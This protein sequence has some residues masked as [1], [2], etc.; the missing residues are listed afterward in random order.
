MKRSVRNIA[1]V[2]GILVVALFLGCAQQNSDSK[3]SGKSSPSTSQSSFA[4]IEGGDA[5]GGQPRS[6]AGLA[7]RP[8]ADWLDL[9]PSGMRAASYALP[10][11]TN[12]SDTAMVAVFF[13][14]SGG[15]GSVQDNIARW[16]GQVT[17]EDGRSREV[18]AIHDKLT[19]KGM[20]VTT[21]EIDGSYTP[22]MG[23]GA[24]S[25]P[26]AGYRLVGAV[27]EGPEGNLFF[28]LTGPKALT[29]KMM[30]GFVS[31][32]KQISKFDVGASAG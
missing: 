6:V 22:A 2:P 16:V 25:G 19:V 30:S 15:G 31:M 28:R 21:V 8:P 20:T 5:L 32:V 13:F 27:I 1:F 12:T 10:D 4:K 23:P 26:K 14:A 29:D 7:F 18:A 17:P 3:T 24:S 11:G 9:G